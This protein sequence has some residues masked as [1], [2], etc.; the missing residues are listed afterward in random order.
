MAKMA[1]HQRAGRLMQFLIALN[2]TRIASALVGRGFCEDDLET[3]FAIL[4]ALVRP[5][6]A[7][8]P[9]VTVTQSTHAV[10]EFYKEAVG[11]ASA[12]LRYR[13]PEILEHL[14][15]MSSPAPV[16]GAQALLEKMACLDKPKA[17]GGFG[18]QGVEA[19][20]LLE[21][22]G[23][24]PEVRAEAQRNLEHVQHGLDGPDALEHAQIADASAKAAEQLTRFYAEWSQVGRAAVTDPN[25][26][27]KMGVRKEPKDHGE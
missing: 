16:F 12:S 9:K 2:D 21:R 5:N 17:E 24:T 14:T 20:A 3:A 23:L 11:I 10:V 15:F 8:V 25:L 22:R 13:F 1:A 7:N 6:L 18:E 26:Q 4:R 19:L 27:R